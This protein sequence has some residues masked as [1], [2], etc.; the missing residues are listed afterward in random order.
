[1][2]GRIWVR[3]RARPRQHVPLHGPLR[4][5]GRERQ[6]PPARRRSRRLHGMRVLVV[7][8][9]ATE[10]PHPGRD[11][12][13]TGS[14]QPTAAAGA[15]RSDAR[16][17]EN[18]CKTGMPFGLVLTDAN[19]PDMT[20]SRWPSR[21]SKRPAVGSTVIMMLT[22]GDRPGDFAGANS[23]AWPPTCSSRSS[24][25]NCSTPIVAGPGES[26]RR[27]D[28]AAADE[29]AAPPSRLPPLAHPAGRRQPRQSEA[30]RRRCLKPRRAHGGRG[31]QRP[32]G[33]RGHAQS[34]DFDL[35]LMDVQMP[36]MD[37]LE[38]TRRD[39]RREKHDRAA[40]CRSSP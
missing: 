10:L 25:R 12:R 1:M 16:S 32:R 29:L 22:S 23:S 31:Q 40:T 26:Q 28:P 9:N 35:V 18:G 20:A 8:D 6:L 11:A 38:A 30:G 7:D 36:E 17:C 24:S 3:K 39:P 4:S 34:A 21:S 2:G 5:A 13:A 27:E 15:R 19:M 37:G 33:R 14:M